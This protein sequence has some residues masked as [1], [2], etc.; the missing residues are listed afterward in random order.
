MLGDVVRNISAIGL[1]TV[2]LWLSGVAAVPRIGLPMAFR[3][4]ESVSTEELARR[5]DSVEKQNADHRLTVLETVS[6]QTSQRLDSIEL[7]VRSALVGLAVVIF[8]A[9]WSMVRGSQQ[10]EFRQRLRPDLE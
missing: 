1:G 8:Q 4:V 2:A 3:Q 6:I 10:R 5:I 7:L 9:V